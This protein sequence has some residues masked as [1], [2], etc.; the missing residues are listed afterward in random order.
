MYWYWGRELQQKLME[1]N[2]LFSNQKINPPRLQKI[3]L[4]QRISQTAST[5]VSNSFIGVFF[6]K[7]MYN[8]FSKGICV[9]F[10]HCFTC[11]LAVS[12]CPIGALQYFAITRTFPFYVLGYIGIIGLSVGRGVC[13]WLCP[14]GLL[15][16]V[17]FKIKSI[18]FSIP[19]T[20]HYLKYVFLVVLVLIVP[21]YTGV[22]WFSQLCPN[23]ALTAGIP[24]VMW[25]PINP[26]TGIPTIAK[27]SINGFFVIK[28]GI[29]LFFLIWFI[30]AK[31][32]FC[33]TSCPFG[34]ILAL[35]NKIS[36]LQLRV[37]HTC[38]KC[39]ACKKICPMD[40]A[41]YHNVTS[42]ECIRCLRCTA[43]PSVKTTNSLCP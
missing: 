29:L 24:W 21:Y 30:L 6:T 5:I 12:S 20:A 43:C 11:P 36:F 1:K 3:S 38:I 13:G 7:T 33:R 31:R 35:F 28:M 15:Q 23:G 34:A 14:F 39:N 25:N 16:D 37:D 18:K 9:P 41:I 19:K 27:E 2:N 40:I 32:P 17:M 10:L 4:F 42:P 22:K 8:G 26:Q